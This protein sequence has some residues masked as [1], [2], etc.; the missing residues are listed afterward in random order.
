M[1]TEWPVGG[2]AR[3]G[4]GSVEAY[5]PAEIKFERTVWA[6]VCGKRKLEVL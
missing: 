5:G 6:G 4:R 1:A 3:L 2:V